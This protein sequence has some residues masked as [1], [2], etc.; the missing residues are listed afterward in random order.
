MVENTCGAVPLPNLTLQP[1]HCAL[2][3]VSEREPA[4]VREHLQ[5]PVRVRSRLV[6]RLEPRRRRQPQLQMRPAL[7][8]AMGLFL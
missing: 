2:R 6:A 3:Q 4:A 5:R 1:E 8:T 7:R